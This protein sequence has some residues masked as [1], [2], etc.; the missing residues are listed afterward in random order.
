MQLD[1]AVRRIP[2]SGVGQGEQITDTIGVRWDFASSV[3][4]KVQI[5][6]IKPSDNGLFINPQPGFS[7]PVTVGAV[8]LDFV[9]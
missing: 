1:G 4:L 7:G 9:F 6:R 5:D 2:V 8:A 3:A